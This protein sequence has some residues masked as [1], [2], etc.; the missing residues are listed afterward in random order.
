MTPAEQTELSA[1]TEHRHECRLAWI[2]ELSNLATNGMQYP[3]VLQYVNLQ[4]LLGALTVSQ[5]R[6]DDFQ[7]STLNPSAQYGR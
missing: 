6:I 3:T 4:R 5:Q 7:A 1:L 2:D